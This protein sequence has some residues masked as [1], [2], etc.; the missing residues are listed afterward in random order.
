MILAKD[1][2]GKLCLIGNTSV[3]WYDDYKIIRYIKELPIEL[4]RTKVTDKLYDILNK[5][6]E[7]M[8]KAQDEVKLRKKCIKI[9]EG[10]KK[11]GTTIS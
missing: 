6:K 8:S 10:L 7:L 4:K 2:E 9:L 1:K 11:E 3:S 5:Q